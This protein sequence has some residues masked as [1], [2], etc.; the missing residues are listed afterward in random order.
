MATQKKKGYLR[1]CRGLLITE[2]NA[3][4]SMP[5]DPAKLWVDTAQE[6]SLENEVAEGETSDLRGGD[7]LLT[8][9]QERDVVIGQNISFRDAR[10]DAELLELV[11]GGTLVTE[12]DDVLG[13][14][15]PKV[16]DQADDIPF[17]AELFVQSFNAEGG[18]EGFLKYKFP[19]CTGIMGGIEHSDQEW[20]T[21]QF[22]LKA[23]ENPSTAA[24]SYRRDFV[25]GIPRAITVAAIAGGGTATAVTDP[26]K[27]G[28]KGETITVTIDVTAGSF[29]TIAVEDADGNAV[30]TTQVQAGEEY[31]FVMPDAA[32]TITVTTTA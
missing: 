18:R 24:S 13:W 23:R 19:Y 6:A 28:I 32:V 26:T 1:G 5:D 3:D 27:F 25:E 12:G 31:T 7:R 10:F 8:R 29:G 2:L 22:A 17:Q 4:G 14:E 9:I 15:A 20:G 16:E 30:A 21:P 11:Q